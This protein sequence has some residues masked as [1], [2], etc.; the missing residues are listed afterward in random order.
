[1]KRSPPQHEA[2]VITQ[3]AA[4]TCAA[5]GLSVQATKLAYDCPGG[6]SSWAEVA[7]CPAP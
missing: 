3:A 7:C 6:Q 2:L 5:A 4:D 1:M